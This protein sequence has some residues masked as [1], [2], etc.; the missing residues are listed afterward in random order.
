M[1]IRNK[2]GRI[3][4]AFSAFDTAPGFCGSTNFL[5]LLIGFVEKLTRWIITVQRFREVQITHGR[6]ARA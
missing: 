3:H 5:S 2:N 1:K 4:A 6:H